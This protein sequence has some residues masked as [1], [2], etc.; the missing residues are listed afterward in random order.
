M[1][2][3]LHQSLRQVEEML[4]RR[5]ASYSSAASKR[6]VPAVSR[7]DLGY[8]YDQSGWVSL[9]LDTRPDAEP[10]GHW[11]RHIKKNHVQFP[12]WQ[13]AY[14]ALDEEELMFV[15]PGNVERSIP[16]GISEEDFVAIFGDELK[17]LLL[18][19]KA[20]GLFDALPKTPSCEPGVPELEGRYGW[21]AH[22]DRGRE[23]LA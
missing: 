2:L 15:L 6:A 9:Y 22:E 13:A 12:E 16:A 14:E 18:S 17:K 5:I 23:N 10:D 4:R 8:Q 11:T 19:A 1:R 20:A 7:I 3:D 21:P